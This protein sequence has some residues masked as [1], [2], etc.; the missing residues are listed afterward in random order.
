[1]HSGGTVC[2]PTR[3]TLLTGRN[4]F[5]DCMDFVYD[6]S[7]MTECE[8]DGVCT[9]G[10]SCRFAPRRTYTVAD[11]VGTKGYESFFGG[12]WHLGS[13]YRDTEHASSPVTHGFSDFNA[14]VDVSPT[15]LTNCQCSAKWI[16]S[17]DFGH[18]G[19]PT[20]CAG[21]GNPCGDECQDGCCFNYWWND[22][23]EP[24]GV[25]NLTWPSPYDDSLYVVDSFRTFLERRNPDKYLAQLSFHNC[26]IPFVGTP[27]AR[28]NCASAVTCRPG[29]YT[30]SELDYYA[31][32]NELDASV[33]AVLDLV[34]D[35]PNTL[36]WFATD[37]GPEMNCPPMGFCDESNL[38]GPGSAGILRG[39]KRDVYEGGHRVPGI[40]SWPSRI[41]GKSRESWE[42]ISTLDFLPTILDILGIQRPQKQLDWPIDG[43]SIVPLVDNQPLPDRGMA[44]WYRDPIPNNQT[45]YAFRYGPWKFVHGSESCT[46][47][48]CSR[49]QLYNLVD[50]LREQRDLSERFPH[51]LHALIHN[52]SIFNA[53]VQNS[54]TYESMCDTTFSPALRTRDETAAFSYRRLEMEFS[55][56]PLATTTAENSPQ[57]KESV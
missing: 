41:S 15:A 29:N 56:T 48:N 38:P 19:K 7:D 50:D 31:C 35:N 9:G 40:I 4:H 57:Q 36:I 34:Q 32:L 28:E 55:D 22:E 42:P 6:C 53:S 17:C 3:A 21:S 18:Y 39:R 5:R 30:D 25:K 10:G 27:A 20:H 52:F 2:S 33:G 13:L 44:W 47:E 16:E 37:N 46:I 26:H 23:L 54:R 24:H 45:G 51:I 8:P 1:M 14:T 12:K 43:T 49:P 11:A